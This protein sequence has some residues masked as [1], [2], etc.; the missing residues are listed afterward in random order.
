MNPDQEN[1]P[2]FR[3]AAYKAAI[4]SVPAKYRL[5]YLIGDIFPSLGWMKERYRCGG[6]KAVL[7]YPHRLGKLWWLV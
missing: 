6:M 1:K 4:K 7:Y 5:Q 3:K 2:E